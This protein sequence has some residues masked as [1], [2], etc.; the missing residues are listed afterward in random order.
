MVYWITGR[1]NSG[2][3][4][5]AK[6]LAKQ[7][8][9]IVIDGD[10]VRKIWG[11]T[12]CFRDSDRYL[13]ILTIARIARLIEKQDKIAIVACISPKRSVRYEAQLLFDQCIEICMPFGELW[14]GT[15]Y[16]E[17]L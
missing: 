9:G 4:T 8:D 15:E 13:N 7:V 17:P 6:R 3:T 16:E 11:T 1:A 2:K 5:L 14:E 12:D 10:E